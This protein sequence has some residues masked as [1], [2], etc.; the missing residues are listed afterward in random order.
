[1]NNSN[2]NKWPYKYLWLNERLL[3]FRFATLETFLIV[4][5][6]S[7]PSFQHNQPSRAGSYEDWLSDFTYEI[8]GD[9]AYSWIGLFEPEVKFSGVKPGWWPE[10]VTW[11]NPR[12]MLKNGMLI[13]SDWILNADETKTRLYFSAICYVEC[14]LGIAREPA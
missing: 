1:M 5:E 8:C 7:C 4:S 11:M 2:T 10:G 3:D 9:L 6:M 14:C 12:S 13:V